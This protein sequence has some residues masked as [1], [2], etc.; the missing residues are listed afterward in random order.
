MKMRSRVL[1]ILARVPLYVAVLLL[2]VYTF[3][4]HLL[5]HP[6]AQTAAE[7]EQSCRQHSLQAWPSL[8]EFR[9]YLREPPGPPQA[10]A[11]VFH[12]NGGHAAGYLVVAQALSR[13]NIRTILAEYP[14]YGPR[15]G[16]L[17]E[18]SLAGD[19]AEAI[20]AAHRQFGPPVLVIGQSLGA[21]VAAAAVARVP[22]LVRGV[23]LITPWDR[24]KSV[25]DQQFPWLPTS[26]LLRDAYDS[27]ANLRAFHG[28]VA[29]LVAED[30]T[31]IPAPIGQS[32]AAQVAEP[33][34]ITLVRGGHNSWSA[35]LPPQWWSETLAFLL[36]PAAIPGAVAR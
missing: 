34:R 4:D 10:T 11:V 24:L 33:K 3:Q 13:M 35:M 23:V 5:H 20:A 22:K 28:P 21:G 7:V 26:L 32:L 18:A 1:G 36:Q 16:K 31:V 8:P 14:S 30:D 6:V 12:G 29:V 2:L 17:D 15:D 19:A 9:G 25:A 27:V